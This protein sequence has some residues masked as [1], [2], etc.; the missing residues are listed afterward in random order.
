MLSHSVSIHTERKRRGHLANA[1]GG[2]SQNDLCDV[3]NGFRR[4]LYN[5]FP[6]IYWFDCLALIN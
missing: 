6:V 5:V 3:F 2:S 1:K 4:S